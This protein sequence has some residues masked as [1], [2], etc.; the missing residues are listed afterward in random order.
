MFC[1]RGK[2]TDPFGSRVPSYL[3]PTD[4]P[5]VLFR[6]TGQG[7]TDGGG[8]WDLN[9]PG[10]RRVPKG[11][12][13]SVARGSCPSFREDIRDTRLGVNKSCLELLGVDVLPTLIGSRNVITFI[14]SL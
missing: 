1:V 2:T 13:P 4:G 9:S 11:R 8:G 14:E 10:V 3:P 12:K 6:D 7:P 5:S